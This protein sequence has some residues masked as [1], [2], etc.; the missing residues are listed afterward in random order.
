[1]AQV[2]GE[3]GERVHRDHQQRG[4]DRDLHGHACDQHERGNDDEAAAG[5]DEARG[6]ADDGAQAEHARDAQLAHALRRGIFG[7]RVVG[8]RP[9]ATA[10]QHGHGRGQHHRGKAA[11][12]HRGRNEAR[13]R[14]AQERARHPRGAEHHARTPEDPAG[15]RV[16][17]RGGDRRHADDEERHCDRVL[18][19]HVEHVDQDG[20]GQDRPTTAQ[21]AEGEPDDER[22][23]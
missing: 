23:G 10:T 8:R 20:H 16:R 4:A 15:T 7:G 14:T 9:R 3:A 19:G 11:E 5:P 2:A 1:V 18:R 21:E 13:D 17:E 6:Q 22:E 12:Q